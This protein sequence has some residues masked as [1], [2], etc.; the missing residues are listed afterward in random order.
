MEGGAEG[1][2][3]ATRVRQMATWAASPMTVQVMWAVA[4][5]AMVVWMS[6]G[7]EERREPMRM[8]ISRVPWEGAWL[9]D[10]C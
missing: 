4:R 9:V 8:R 10:G 2:V 1:L 5:A 6:E 7:S 3:R